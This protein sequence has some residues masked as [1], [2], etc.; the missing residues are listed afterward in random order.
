MSVSPVRYN[1]SGAIILRSFHRVVALGDG[2]TGGISIDR[3][4][5]EPVDACEHGHLGFAR[6]V[7]A[8]DVGNA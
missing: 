7:L 4:E 3:V 1:D 5:R 6:G 2:Y 8:C